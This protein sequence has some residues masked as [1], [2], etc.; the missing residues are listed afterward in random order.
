MKKAKV[1]VLFV[2]TFGLLFLL[3]GC[4]LGLE[5]DGAVTTR[6]HARSPIPAYPRQIEG[7]YLIRNRWMPRGSVEYLRSYTDARRQNQVG[8]TIYDGGDINLYLWKLYEITPGKFV[9][10]N[11]STYKWLYDTEQWMMHLPTNTWWHSA[12]ATNDY[13]IQEQSNIVFWN[14]DK[15]SEGWTI[16]KNMGTGFYLNTELH[17]QTGYKDSVYLSST[18]P[19]SSGWWSAQWNFERY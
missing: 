19:S 14:L 18:T 13:Y 1:I 5:N 16:F 2:A 3:A 11:C 10:E 7:N 9:I 17:S 4:S 12:G 15:N 8:C 6:D